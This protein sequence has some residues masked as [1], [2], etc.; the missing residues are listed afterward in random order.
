MLKE[1]KLLKTKRSLQFNLRRTCQLKAIFVE[2]LP[3]WFHD[4]PLKHI[5]ES[6]GFVLNMPGI[7]VELLAIYRD[8][9]CTLTFRR[10]PTI[11]R[12]VKLL[13]SIFRVVV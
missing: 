9:I 11:G 1:D 3:E 4:R 7:F 2:I 6:F 12:S 10:F 13:V 8:K 5:Q